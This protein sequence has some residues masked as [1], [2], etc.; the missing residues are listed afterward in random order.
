MQCEASY[1][2]A[3]PAPETQPFGR[4]RR[5]VAGTGPARTAM[6]APPCPFLAACASLPQ[7]FFRPCLSRIATWRLVL[8]AVGGPGRVFPN[9]PWRPW[10]PL[11]GRLNQSPQ[12]CLLHPRSLTSRGTW[13][14][15][16]QP[17]GTE[18]SSPP[19]GCEGRP[20]RAQ[21]APWPQEMPT[22]SPLQR[23]WP[24][25]QALSPPMQGRTLPAEFPRL[26]PQTPGSPRREKLPGYRVRYLCDSR[27]LSSRHPPPRL[28]GEEPTR[29]YAVEVRQH[30]IA[31]LP[32]SPPSR[33]GS[34]QQPQP[35]PTSQPRPHRGLCAPEIPPAQLG[36]RIPRP[37]STPSGTR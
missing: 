15:L 34:L 24:P 30:L 14:Q 20:D 27:A 18:Y 13:R 29:G 33:P 5:S 9:R 35:S 26:L 22:R 11:P 2:I 7:M 10:R 23:P 37:W 12:Q 1:A 3:S 21:D 31:S 8:H 16:Q 25:L 32:R 17:C 6:Q 4:E 19:A 36:P 28:H